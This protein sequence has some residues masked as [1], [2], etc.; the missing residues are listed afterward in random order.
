MP[1][2]MDL[3][4]LLCRPS[5]GGSAHKLLKISIRSAWDPAAPPPGPRVSSLPG[6]GN[7]LACQ[8]AGG[9]WL[10]RALWGGGQCR[11]L[12][13]RNGP[14]QCFPLAPHLATP[15]GFWQ[16]QSNHKVQGNQKLCNHTSSRECQAPVL[17]S[18][19]SRLVGN[20]K[21][22]DGQVHSKL[23]EHGTCFPSLRPPGLQVPAF[24]PLCG[25][26]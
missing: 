16:C 15:R 3:R 14:L 25:H 9:E 12:S 8:W 7:W 13:N 5:M 19:N 26:S 17:S 10:E 23:C 1:H 24:P 21:Q 18:D 11:N 2:G 22:A 4:G 6:T 20:A